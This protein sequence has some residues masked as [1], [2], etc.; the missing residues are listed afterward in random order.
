MNQ[1]QQQLKVLIALCRRLDKDA[2]KYRQE[3]AALRAAEQP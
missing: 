1:R 2:A 3:L